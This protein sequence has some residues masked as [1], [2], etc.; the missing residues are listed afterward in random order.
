MPRL[1][2]A[3]RQRIEPVQVGDRRLSASV[4]AYFA[5]SL[6]PEAGCLAGPTCV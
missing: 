4:A 6:G 3:T 2:R 5:S 1:L